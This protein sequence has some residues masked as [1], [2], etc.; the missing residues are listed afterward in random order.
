MLAAVVAV[1]ADARHANLQQLRVVAA[2]RLVAVRAVLEHWRVLPQEGTSAFRVAT[3]A[4]FIRGALDELPGIRR[5][6]WIVAAR[7]GYF[8]FAVGHVRR[9][10]QLRAA[11]LVAL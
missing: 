3:Q 9:A 8:A 10:L 7:A 4:V 6:V 1:V 11:H 2:V 5:A